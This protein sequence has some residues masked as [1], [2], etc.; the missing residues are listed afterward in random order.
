MENSVNEQGIMKWTD[1]II[2]YYQYGLI[3]KTD[4]L[5]LSKVLMRM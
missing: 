3:V 1:F 4:Y 5:V 2:P